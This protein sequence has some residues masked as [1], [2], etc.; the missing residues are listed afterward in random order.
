M[1]HAYRVLLLRR[2]SDKH[3]NQS[4]HPK[5][6]PLKD[7]RCSIASVLTLA[8]KTTTKTR[9]RSSSL[10]DETLRSLQSKKVK[11][12]LPV[13]D[14][15]YDNQAHW[16]V[17][18]QKRMQCRYCLTGN[19]RVRCVKCDVGLCLNERSNCFLAFHTK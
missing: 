13:A 5:H 12:V 2:S 4:K 6:M 11:T 14:V 15:R 10:N 8:G 9:G 1:V 3:L 16:A 18:D 17:Y 7:F 19:T